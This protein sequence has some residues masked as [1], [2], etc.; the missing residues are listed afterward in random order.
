MLDCY[1]LED[2]MGQEED[3]SAV[4]SIRE[5]SFQSTR[6]SEWKN[7]NYTLNRDFRHWALCDHLMDFLSDQGVDDTFSDELSMALD[8]QNYIHSFSQRPQKIFQEPI[9]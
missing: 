4:F 8:H 5:M 9:E 7:L 3:K 1:H 6:E 2:E